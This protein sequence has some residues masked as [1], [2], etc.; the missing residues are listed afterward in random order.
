MSE[1]TS[2]HLGRPVA[3]ILDGELV[4]LVTVRQPLS[5]RLVFGG[6]FTADEARRIASGLERW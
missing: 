2:K 5:N 3:I 6:D 1:A 4:A